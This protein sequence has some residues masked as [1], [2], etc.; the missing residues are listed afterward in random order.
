MESHWKILKGRGTSSGL[1]NLKWSYDSPHIIC[2]PKEETLKSI[3]FMKHVLSIYD[4]SVSNQGSIAK[5]DPAL[6][7]VPGSGEDRAI[8]HGD[9]DLG[10][11]GQEYLTRQM[12]VKGQVR[13]HD[14]EDLARWIEQAEERVPRW[15]ERV[16]RNTSECGLFKE[17]KDL[18]WWERGV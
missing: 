7:L 8:D 13:V 1:Y 17:Q 4:G 15:R 5:K 6:S 16:G 2:T 10:S 18:L 14:V 3:L 11:L 9:Q 12:E